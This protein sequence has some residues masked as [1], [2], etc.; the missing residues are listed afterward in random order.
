M[1]ALRL[2]SFV[3]L[4]AL[5]PAC[6]LLDGL[7]EEAASPRAGLTI[8]RGT[9]FG[10]CAGYCQTELTAT[11]EGI[12]FVRRARAT[13]D[14]TLTEERDLSAD[15]WRTLAEQV[16]WDQLDAM[17]EVYGCPDCADGG[18][19]W[20]EVIDEGRTNRITFEYG[21]APREIVTLV[22]DLRALAASFDGGDG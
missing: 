13:E 22:S 20:L 6:S 12:V 9:S 8:T 3:G 7:H 17:D 14:P 18:T 5:L 10:L 11:A 15:T 16:N 19:E 1:H 2:F 21:Q 4:L